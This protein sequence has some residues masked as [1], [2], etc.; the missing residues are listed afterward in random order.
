MATEGQSSGLQQLEHS[1]LDHLGIGGERSV[2]T[3]A[4]SGE[5]RVCNVA[6]PGLQR[7]QGAWQPSPFD[8]MAQEL[9]N[10]PGNRE[11]RRPER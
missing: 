11:R 4:E 6:N 5:N 1:V 3:V 8:F 9:E 10:V 2:R 7:K